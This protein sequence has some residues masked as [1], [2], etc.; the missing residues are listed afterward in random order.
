MSLTYCSV[1]IKG[2]SLYTVFALA[3][4][5]DDVKPHHPHLTP[6]TPVFSQKFT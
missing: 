2:F 1:L 5:Y 4:P 3:M 6:T